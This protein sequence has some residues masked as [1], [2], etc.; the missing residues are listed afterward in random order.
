MRVPLCKCCGS[1]SAHQ[2]AFLKLAA[3]APRFLERDLRMVWRYRLEREG[4]KRILRLETPLY[5]YVSSYSARYI[6]NAST[7]PSLGCK[8]AS[9]NCPTISKPQLC[10]DRTAFSFVATT[11]LNCIARNERAFARSIEWSHIIRASPRPCAAAAVTYP[12]LPTLPPPPS[13]F[14]C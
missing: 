8:N 5:S 12:Q 7:Y 10:H 2:M 6:T 3:T 9:G 11:K 13:S 1:A 4:L 14:A